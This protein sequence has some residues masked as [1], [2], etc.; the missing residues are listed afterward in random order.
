MYTRELGNDPLQDGAHAIRIDI[1]MARKVF[2]IPVEDLLR[3]AIHGIG[4]WVL[5]HAAPPHPLPLGNSVTVR[6]TLFR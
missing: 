1:K 3:F 4:D 6:M 5:A 2:C